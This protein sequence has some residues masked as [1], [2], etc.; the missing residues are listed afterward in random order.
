MLLFLSLQHLEAIVGLL[1]QFQYC[2]SGN[3]EAREEEDGWLEQQV[4][5]A[6]KIHTIFIEFAVLYRCDSWHLKTITMVTSKFSNH[7]QIT[8]TDIIIVKKFE[9]F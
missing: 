4:C 8:A 9:I 3:K 5:G 7:T 2:I 6:A 1:T